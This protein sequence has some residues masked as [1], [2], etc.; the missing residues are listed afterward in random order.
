MTTNF[1]ELLKVLGQARVDFII[2]GGA[3]GIAHGA[4]TF[5]KNLEVVYSR[6]KDNIERLVLA[7]APH[8]PYLRGAPNGTSI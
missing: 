7:L 3:A 5:T 4:A 1:P 6:S 2:V 8:K